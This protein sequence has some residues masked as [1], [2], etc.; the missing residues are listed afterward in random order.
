MF[1]VQKTAL[2][3]FGVIISL[4]FAGISEDLKGI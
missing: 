3:L 4:Y 1:P 2:T